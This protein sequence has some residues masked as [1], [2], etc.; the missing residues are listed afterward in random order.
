LLRIT[1]MPSRVRRQPPWWILSADERCGGC[2]FQFAHGTGVYCA[3]C[4]E[5]LCV[6]CV[7]FQSGETFCVGCTPAKKAGRI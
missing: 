3:E 7:T 1:A 5:I 6:L 4:D 2:E